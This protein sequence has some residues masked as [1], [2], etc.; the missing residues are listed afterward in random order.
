MA[1]PGTIFFFFFQ[2]YI[3]FSLCVPEEKINQAITRIKS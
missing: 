1:S 2:G 3:R